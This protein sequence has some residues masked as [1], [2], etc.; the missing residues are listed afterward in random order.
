MVYGAALQALTRRLRASKMCGM[1]VLIY[2]V[3]CGVICTSRLEA[4]TQRE[5]TIIYPFPEH[6]LEFILE[7]YIEEYMLYVPE[8]RARLVQASYSDILSFLSTPIPGFGH[9]FALPPE[10]VMEFA[11]EGM[12]VPFED[13]EIKFSSPFL[14]DAKLYAIP[15]PMTSYGLAMP[16]WCDM[17][18]IASAF[19]REVYSLALDRFLA[20]SWK[21]RLEGIAVDHNNGIRTS[22]VSADFYLCVSTEFGIGL[23]LDL[24]EEKGSMEGYGRVIETVA[25]GPMPVSVR[26][27]LIEVPWNT[28]FVSGNL[29]WS[30]IRVACSI[31]NT[32]Y[33]L[34]GY[35]E[36]QRMEALLHNAQ[37]RREATIAPREGQ[38][39]IEIPHSM[40]V[41][42]IHAVGHTEGQEGKYGLV[43]EVFFDDENDAPEQVPKLMLDCNHISYGI[44]WSSS[45]AADILA[46]L[47]FY[48]QDDRA[49]GGPD[50][51]IINYEIDTHGAAEEEPDTPLLG[52]DY[53]WIWPEDIVRLW[54]PTVRMEQAIILADACYS[55]QHGSKGC[56][57]PDYC[58]M[59]DAFIVGGAWTYTGANDTVPIRMDDFT[60]E[61]WESLTDEGEDVASAESDAESAQG[62]SHDKFGT[63][64]HKNCKGTD[65][66]GIR[67]HDI[68]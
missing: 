57:W 35:L 30:Q 34:T 52:S 31:G 60:L 59:A 27:V 68:R 44:R 11:S 39:Y 14:L 8:I 21:I 51:D 10:L 5:I 45:T 37:E 47:R 66:H 65:G 25:H 23:A 6:R 1:K 15:I 64:D 2:V 67:C 58:E 49:R 24:L 54:S 22:P 29:Q 56:L 17:P 48:N 62:F 9:L 53:V 13:E 40:P 43:E 18:E 3:L 61:F 38:Y 36:S 42:E 28:L 50:R 12:L 7:E 33:S 19:A 55:L 32:V 26:G 16:Y 46:H 4:S 63:Y 41:P 20:Q